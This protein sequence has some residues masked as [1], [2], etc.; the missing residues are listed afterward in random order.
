M[1]QVVAAE[2]SERD[3]LLQFVDAQR[4]ALRRA[5]GGLTQEQASAH[6]TRSELDLI[7]LVKHVAEAESTWIRVILAGRPSL[8]PRDQTN[9]ADSF[10]L[11]EGESIEGVLA[12]WDDVVAETAEVIGGLPDLD[13]SVALPDRRWF[14][15]GE[16]RTARWILLHLVA[17]IARH[18][19]HADIIRESLDGATAF[20][21][22]PEDE[23]RPAD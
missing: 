6:P 21:L 15:K 18:A 3:A 13:V 17:E 12:F 16:R 19:G 11:V 22:M 10:H 7:G 5:L 9:W 8:R 1:P 2:T 20:S 23:L 4:A 14:P